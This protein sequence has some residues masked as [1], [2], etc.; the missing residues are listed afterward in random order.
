MMIEHKAQGGLIKMDVTI[1]NSTIR[2]L[3]ITGDFFIYPEG[4]LFDL[5]RTLK[6]KT[7]KDAVTVVENFLDGVKAPGIT[8]TDFKILLKKAFGET[9]AV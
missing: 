2:D 3:K 6:G 1:K 7:E 9:N 5:E 4:A 8:L